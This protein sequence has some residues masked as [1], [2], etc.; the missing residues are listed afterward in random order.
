MPGLLRLVA[1]IRRI[2]RFGTGHRQPL[3]NGAD[4]R[5]SGRQRLPAWIVRAIAFILSAD[6]GVRPHR[7]RCRGKASLRSNA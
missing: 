3:Q 1:K 5:R 7:V 2:E 4:G 6:T